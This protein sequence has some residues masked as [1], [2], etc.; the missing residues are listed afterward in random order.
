MVVAQGNSRELERITFEGYIQ[1]SV[2]V[3]G[4]V[5]AIGGQ[6]KSRSRPTR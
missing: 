4:I 6:C 5:I 2:V 3:V 1:G